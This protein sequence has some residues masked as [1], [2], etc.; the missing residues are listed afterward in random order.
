[1]V[2]YNH[3]ADLTYLYENDKTQE[4][5]DLFLSICNSNNILDI[6]S[7]IKEERF[8]EKNSNIKILYDEKELLIFKENFILNLP[9]PNPITHTIGEFKFVLDYPNVIEHTC[10][11]MHCIKCIKY[12]EE[13]H[14]VNTNKDFNL[15]PK[16][17]Y[18]QL[19]PKIEEYIQELNKVLIYKV[20]SITSGFI[21]NI[22]LIIKIIYL[23][24][25]T[26]FKNIID[27]RLF[28]MKEYNFTYEAFDKISFL[29]ARQYLTKGI[30][31]INERNNPET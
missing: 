2:S 18:N 20:G 30:K 10:K 16:T 3:V 26:S 21:L 25:V 7:F 31:I 11:P 23:A 9:E 14:Y 1:M 12:K 24:F 27:E 28:L 19:Q 15:I 22:D 6:L 13:V 17:V 5:I 4:F 8:A 29:Q